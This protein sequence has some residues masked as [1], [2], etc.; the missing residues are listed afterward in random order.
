[1]A[2]DA[3]VHVIDD[4]EAVRDSLAFLLKSAALQVQTYD[5]ATAF[6]AAIK[7]RPS[8]CIVTDIRMP[9]LSGIELL[10]RLAELR[11]DVPVIVITGHGDIPL[12][13]EAMKAGA[14]DFIEKPFEDDMIL[15]RSS[16][17]SAKATRTAPARPSDRRSART[18][19]N[20]VAA[21]ARGAGRPGR[22]GCRTR[23]SPTI[24]ESARARS[25]SIAP[26]S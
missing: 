4:D 5:S 23:P 21:R 10:R 26:M 9:E 2:D 17:R 13:V 20:P 19:C 11:I 8:G 24:S 18:A 6:L 25:R 1:M 7:G 22:R 15:T 16:P 12:A 3:V 14:V